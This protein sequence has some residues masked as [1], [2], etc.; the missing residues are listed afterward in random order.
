MMTS[1]DA[2]AAI[3]ALNGQMFEGKSMTVAHVSF[4]SSHRLLRANMVKARRGR[5]RTPTPGQYHGVKV[6]RGP[7]RGG[8][9]GGG[10]YGASTLVPLFAQY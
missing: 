1:N 4:F 9:G 3:E 8:Y 6:E 10:G 5:A 7:P 2:N